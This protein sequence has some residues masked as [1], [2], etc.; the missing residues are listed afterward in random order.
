MIFEGLNEK[1][2]QGKNFIL[3]EENG[4]KSFFRNC[5]GVEEKKHQTGMFSILE[6]YKDPGIVEVAWFVLPTPH[7][8]PTP[9]LSSS[10][11]HSLPS[12]SLTPSLYFNSLSL[13]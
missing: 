11:F 9:P 13:Q 6:N 4:K 3:R 8:L 7:S 10:I 5:F 12:L 2:E 1:I